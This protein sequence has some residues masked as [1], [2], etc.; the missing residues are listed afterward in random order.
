MM[1][2]CPQVP[3][4]DKRL[5]DGLGEG[6]SYSAEVVG[7]MVVKRPLEVRKDSLDKE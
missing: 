7:G 4:P 6:V 2:F 3:K 1:Q 5:S